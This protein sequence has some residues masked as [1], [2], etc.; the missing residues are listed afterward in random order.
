MVGRVTLL[1][2]E[3]HVLAVDPAAVLAHRL[4]DALLGICKEI[5]SLLDRPTVLLLV[6]VL[7]QREHVSATS[8]GTTS[9]FLT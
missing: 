2:E 6:L 7:K 1:A 8:V 4:L 9:H 5:L 3:Y